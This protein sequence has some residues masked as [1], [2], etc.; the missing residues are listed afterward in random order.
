MAD[1]AAWLKM[2]DMLDAAHDQVTEGKTL[3]VDNP[4]I[5]VTIERDGYKVDEPDFP[6]FDGLDLD[7]LAVKCFMGGWIFTC[8][9]ADADAEEPKPH[10][11]SRNFMAGE[12]FVEQQCLNGGFHGITRYINKDGSQLREVYDAT[13]GD[14]K[15]SCKTL[16]PDGS[17]KHE[18][19]FPPES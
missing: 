1:E 10:G 8:K 14:K 5:G 11:L 9:K 2:R 3:L 13:A 7:D 12:Q 4:E 19:E 6:G 18:G 15:L 17:L 16:N